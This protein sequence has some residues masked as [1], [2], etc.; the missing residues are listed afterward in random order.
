M[1]EEYAGEKDKQQLFIEK[2]N[3][4]LQ[5][6]YDPCIC[7]CHELKSEDS[8]THYKCVY[9][10]LKNM[11]SREVQKVKGRLIVFFTFEV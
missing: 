1:D 4:T 3:S 11:M 5:D 6:E 9:C 8:Y 7:M 10:L 2:I